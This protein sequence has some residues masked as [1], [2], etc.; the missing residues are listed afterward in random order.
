[1]ASD[2]ISVDARLRSLLNDN[3]AGVKVA[4]TV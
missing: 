2:N 1:M 4:F 3:M